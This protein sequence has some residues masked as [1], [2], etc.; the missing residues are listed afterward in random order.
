MAWFAEI[1]ID[2]VH[3]FI[4]DTW[5]SES[6]ILLL[7]IITGLSVFK[8]L[9]SSRLLFYLDPS[10]LSYN[11]GDWEWE[12]SATTLFT[13][14]FPITSPNLTWIQITGHLIGCTDQFKESRFYLLWQI[15]HLLWVGEVLMLLSFVRETHRKKKTREIL[16]DNIF[17]RSPTSDQV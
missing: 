16:W 9:S 4:C 7:H 5:P 2:L 11:P 3:C 1:Y 6:W 10:Y 14:S 15:Q 12:S 13:L 8:Y 17:L